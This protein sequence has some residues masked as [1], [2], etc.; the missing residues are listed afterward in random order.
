MRQIILPRIG[1]DT[2]WREAAR[3]LLALDVPA[4]QVLWS[5]GVPAAPDL[6]ATGARVAASAPA[7]VPRSFLTLARDVIWHSEPERFARLYALLRRVVGDRHL[8][9]DRG[10]PDLAHLHRLAKEVRRDKH[11]MTAFV[12]FREVEGT[13]ARRRFAAWFEPSHVIAEPIAPFFANRFGDMDWVILT[14]DLSVEFTDGR[15][16]Y[17]EGRPRPT[18]PEDTTEDLWRTYFQNI[19]NPARLKVQAMQSEMPRKYWKNLPEADLI[20]RMIATAQT[21]ARAMADAA[22]TLPPARAARI[23]RR[24]AEAT[25]PQAQTQDQVHAALHDG[26]G[27]NGAPVAGRQGPAPHPDGEIAGQ[28]LR[29]PKPPS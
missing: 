4:S 20:P 2:A 7:H 27:H 10:D 1:T 15:I 16:S 12:R 28:P 26:V 11:K 22:P 21:R 23:T 19:F 3:G 8:M 9:A 6:F 18:L 17:A 13:G 24:L 14:P 25:E 29:P 5:R